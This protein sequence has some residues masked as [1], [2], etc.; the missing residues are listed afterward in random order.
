MK[1]SSSADLVTVPRVR[2]PGSARDLDPSVGC[3]EGSCHVVSHSQKSAMAFTSCH[4][5]KFPMLPLLVF[6]AEVEGCDRRVPGLGCTES[7][8]SR[9]KALDFHKLVIA[10]C[11]FHKNIKLTHFVHKPV[12]FNAIKIIFPYNP[13]TAMH[14][15]LK[16][17]TVIHSPYRICSCTSSC[18]GMA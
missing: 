1:S 18:N 11:I 10:R 8:Q 13:Q 7:L 5:P 12:F 14:F 16:T 3:D 17:Q 6:S 9:K 4:L 15:P 2:A